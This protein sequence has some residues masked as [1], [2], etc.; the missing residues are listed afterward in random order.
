M[1]T[2]TRSMTINGHSVTQTRMTMQQALEAG[3]FA[4][5]SFA[6]DWTG[7]AE[8]RPHDWLYA[9][10]VGDTL[11]GYVDGE[12]AMFDTLDEWVESFARTVPA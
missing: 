11:I 8:K 7:R 1:K 9:Y 10:H 12:G 2:E 5:E 3:Y 6:G 4:N